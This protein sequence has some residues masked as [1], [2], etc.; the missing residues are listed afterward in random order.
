VVRLSGCRSAATTTTF[1]S[2]AVEIPVFEAGDVVRVRNEEFLSVVV[3]PTGRAC[4]VPDDAPD[5]GA[6]CC[7]PVALVRTPLDGKDGAKRWVEISD[8]TGAVP[9]KDAALNASDSDATLLDH[10]R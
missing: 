6:V 3:L 9:E 4:E 8:L 2:G 5:L 7:V 10:P 1:G